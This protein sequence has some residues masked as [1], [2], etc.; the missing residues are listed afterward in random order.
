MERFLSEL[1]PA[2]FDQW[3]AFDVVEGFGPSK[4][5]RT[6]ANVGAGIAAAWGGEIP[7]AKFIPDDVAGLKDAMLT[8]E[9]RAEIEAAQAARVAKQ[10]N[11]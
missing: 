6:M 10:I 3:R 2:E 8:D 5:E 11:H 9:E 1:S 4:L 7:P